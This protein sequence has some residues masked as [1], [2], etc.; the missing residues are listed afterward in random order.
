MRVE[1]I[2]HWVVR[3]ILQRAELWSPS[4][5]NL[6]L[7]TGLVESGYQWLD[8]RGGDQPGPAYGPWQMERLTYDSIWELQ[9]RYPMRQKCLAALGF[10]EVPPVDEL[11]GNLFLGA[12]M[13]RL[14]Y[15]TASPPLP[16]ATDATGMARYWKQY[17]NTP[18]GKG[19]LRDALQIFPSV[20]VNGG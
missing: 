18:S 4:A 20:C 9:L 6:V 10:D 15:L 7:G 2:R 14:K 11:H 13:C 3:P 8:Q 12:L 1:E 5:E 16:E 19:I 17:Y